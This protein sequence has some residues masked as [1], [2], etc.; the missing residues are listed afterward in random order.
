MTA[1]FHSLNKVDW[2]HKAQQAKESQRAE[3][4]RR[5]LEKKRKLLAKKRG[6]KE[7]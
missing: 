2:S 3:K 5:F 4:T 7:R 1:K 6:L